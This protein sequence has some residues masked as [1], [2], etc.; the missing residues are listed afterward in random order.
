[1]T[2]SGNNSQDKKRE[3]NYLY[4]VQLA[5][6]LISHKEVIFEETAL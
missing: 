3:K 6:I 4:L 1:M 5:N 2:D